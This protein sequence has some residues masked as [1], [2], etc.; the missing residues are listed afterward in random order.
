MNTK[1]CVVPDLTSES[2]QGLS[3]CEAQHLD[4]H[5]V[6]IYIGRHLSNTG[7][8]RMSSIHTQFCTR[9]GHSRME[10]KVL[11]TLF[12]VQNS[13]CMTKFNFVYRIKFCLSKCNYGDTKQITK[14]TFVDKIQKSILLCP[15]L[16]RWRGQYWQWMKSQ[17]LIVREA[18]SANIG[19]TSIITGDILLSAAGS[20]G[21][22]CQ[23]TFRKQV[24]K[25][26]RFISTEN[27]YVRKLNICI[28][29][30]FLSN[31]KVREQVIWK[32]GL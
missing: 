18:S 22:R 10:R 13:F 26:I 24:H 14:M 31:R 8:S 3:C 23:H 32:T 6:P 17:G 9:R 5:V 28:Y 4:E 27:I 29:K 25:A 2:P 16:G 7:Q 1:D 20:S 21:R 12:C 30:R 19:A 11:P 15:V